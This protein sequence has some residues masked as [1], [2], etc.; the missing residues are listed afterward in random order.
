MAEVRSCLFVFLICVTLENVAPK[1]IFGDLICY[2]MCDYDDDSTS[3]DDYDFCGC[4]PR[5]GRQ[6]TTT[7]STFPPPLSPGSNPSM[8]FM[9][10]PGQGVNATLTQMGGSWLMNFVPWGGQGGAPAPGAPAPTAAP[11]A[12]AAP[13]AATP[14]AAAPAAAPAATP[15]PAASGATTAAAAATTAAPTTAA[16]GK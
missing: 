11:A 2:F 16:A 5:L 13:P 12:A 9:I 1:P 6:R 8:Q 15:A 4:N 7:T 10:P 3:T 14:P